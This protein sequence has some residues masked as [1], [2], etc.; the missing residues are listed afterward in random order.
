MALGAHEGS[1]HQDA[2]VVFE[3]LGSSCQ[4]GV[5]L[6]ASLLQWTLHQGCRVCHAV[7]AGCDK[8]CYCSTIVH[9]SGADHQPG[10]L[11]LGGQL[12]AKQLVSILG[13]GH[14]CITGEP[15]W[16][17]YNMP[18]ELLAVYPKGSFYCCYEQNMGVASC[19]HVVYATV[20][21]SCYIPT[22]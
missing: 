12:E 13:H 6:W 20:I 21:C 8:L 15:H 16:H 19:L 18:A 9:S 1:S 7:H 5:P 3:Q 10:W 14:Q 2:G 22:C 17:C 11:L 4:P